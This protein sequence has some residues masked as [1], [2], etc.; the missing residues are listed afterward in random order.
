[1]LNV[2][3]C[4]RDLPL[5]LAQ[6]GAQRHHVLTRTEAA[7]QQTELMK[8]LEP[9]GIVDVR[10]AAWNLLHVSGVDQQHLQALGLQ[11]LEHRDPVHARRLHRHGGDPDSLEPVGQSMQILSEALKGPYGLGVAIWRHGHHVKP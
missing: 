8:L 1:M 7:A 10:L 9:L 3:R 4:I 2:R 6:I 11:N 5:P